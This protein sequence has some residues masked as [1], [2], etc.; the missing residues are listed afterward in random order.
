MLTNPLNILRPVGLALTA[1]M[2]LG[3][4]DA[5][6]ASKLVLG[7]SITNYRVVTEGSYPRQY[8]RAG[9][10]IGA[11][12]C[13]RSGSGCVTGSRTY[14]VGILSRTSTNRTASGQAALRTAIQNDG[15][16]A[17]S[18]W[19]GTSVHIPCPFR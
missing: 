16:N 13:T 12:I 8:L 7:C 6:A 1:V 2:L 4:A 5:M 3:T 14:Y 10:T 18:G 11:D 15:Y 9:A 17:V 19:A